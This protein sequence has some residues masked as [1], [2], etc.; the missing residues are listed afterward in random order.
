MKEF[1]KQS[2]QAGN[3]FKITEQAAFPNAFREQKF[4]MFLAKCF[5]FH[6]IVRPQRR[7]FLSRGA[8]KMMMGV[9][10]WY[11]RIGV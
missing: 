5:D 4:F 7:G 3:F 8:C 11:A 1:F 9:V 2:C 6:K 10:E